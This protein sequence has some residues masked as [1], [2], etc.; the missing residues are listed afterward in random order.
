VGKQVDPSPG[1]GF[2]Q[3][4]PSWRPKSVSTRS[5]WDVW[6]EH[7]ED[8]VEVMRLDADPTPERVLLS[9]SDE[10]AK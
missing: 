4:L 3:L 8:P 7:L 1:W 2:A 6:L 9:I 5:R 10:G